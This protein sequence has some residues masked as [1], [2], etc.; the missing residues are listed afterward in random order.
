MIKTRKIVGLFRVFASFGQQF[1]RYL[2]STT[3]ES[4]E[5]A[6]EHDEP[7]EAEEED[8]PD[9]KTQ[10]AQEGETQLPRETGLSTRTLEKIE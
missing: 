3:G 6:R 1:A 7:G 8:L 5:S 2:C 4:H 10:G 9:D